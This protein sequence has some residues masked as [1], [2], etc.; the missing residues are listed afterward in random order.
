MANILEISGWKGSI[1]RCIWP[2]AAV[3][4]LLVCIYLCMYEC[5]R[6]TEK[7]QK[8]QIILVTRDKLLEKKICWMSHSID[9]IYYLFICCVCCVCVLP[10]QWM[11]ESHRISL[12]GCSFSPL[13]DQIQVIR[14]SHLSPLSHLAGPEFALMDQSTVW[15]TF[16]VV[17]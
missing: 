9:F 15:N 16:G 5:M 14:L 6:E 3:R 10:A 4:V 8:P 11:C 1:K 2:W 13:S 7:F 12:E 17:P